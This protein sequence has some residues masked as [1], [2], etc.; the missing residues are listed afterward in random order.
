MASLLDA[1]Y[2]S[3][4]DDVKG[5]ASR[6][7]HTHVTAAP[8]VPIENAVDL[9][10]A[11]A[12]P[13]EN[14][15]TYNATFDQLTRPAAG[16][17]NPF[18]SAHGIK[19]KN[20]LTGNAEEVMIS[21]ATF[22]TQ[23]RT[24]Q[25]LGYTKDPSVAGAYVGNMENVALFGGR[26]AVQMRPSKEASAALRRKRQ[27][28]GD[29]SIVEGEGAYLGPWAKYQN[30]EQV[31]EEDLAVAGEELA[32][33]EEY[34]EEEIVPSNMP[35]MDKRATE[36]QE[37][38]SQ[39]ETTE[40][41]GAEQFDYQGRTYMHVPQD[42]DVDLKKE[43]GSIKNYIPKKLIHTWKSH[44]KPIT[45]IR[46]FPSSGHLLLSSSADSKIKIWDVYHSRELLRTYSGHSSS[47]SDTTFHPSGTTF[48]S[49][50]YDRQIKLWDTEYGK[51]VGRFSTGK[52]PHVVRFNPDPNH[53]HEFLAGM[54]DKKIVQFD[55]RSG[56]IT[57]EYDHHLAAINTLT[58]VDNNRR[59]ISTSD[60][61]S[62]RAWEYN[63]PVP[64][65]F[66]AEPY[67]YALVRAAPHPNGKYVAFQSGDNQIVVYASTDKFRQNRKKNFR[68][69]NNAGYAIDVAISPDGQ[70][71][72]SGDSGGYVCF[73][74]W[75]TGKMWH[76]IQAGGKE[77]SAVTCVDWHP[78]ETSKV[79][80]AGLEGVIKYWD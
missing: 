8:D 40:F 47:V 37:D 60:D 18:R 57:Q 9:Q 53:W 19:R 35:A 63:I 45:S 36:Y 75:K 20:V 49:A 74:D 61:K 26:D 23:H 52:T 65:K 46:F 28:K 14:A 33:D 24:F 76:K 6:S 79:A 72:T 5:V 51:C 41:H 42:L 27:K 44:T 3:S 25:S 2:D 70:F 78:Q 1:N 73:W 4:D 11:L 34:V 64:I 56:E 21:D 13:T 59:F 38:M 50:S 31:Y 67:L 58:F 16:P 39:S 69:H 15:L 62:L 54:S 48:L 77:G 17:A 12:K 10:L 68:G 80:T 30:E 43:V 71:V 22:T 55:T 66:I 32:S 29:S 7:A